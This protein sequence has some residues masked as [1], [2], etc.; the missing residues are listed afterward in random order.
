MFSDFDISSFFLSFK[1]LL[2]NCYSSTSVFY[3]RDSTQHMSA[4]KF[5]AM[6][7]DYVGQTD[8]TA[9]ENDR[10]LAAF[11][12]RHDPKRSKSL[13]VLRAD[14]DGSDKKPGPTTPHAW[15][16]KLNCDKRFLN[17]S[18]AF[19]FF[20]RWPAGIRLLIKCFIWDSERNE[21]C[22]EFTVLGSFFSFFSSRVYTWT[23]SRAV[24]GVLG[25]S[26]RALRSG[27]ESYL[28]GYF[29]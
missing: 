25:R 14:R 5:Y 15:G 9:V 29:I 4:F 23:L 6:S 27:S 8:T 17:C 20:Y 11:A 22:I 24:E 7:Y 10:P 3:D 18:S 28:I 2:R 19:F 12:C 21:E 13:T 26:E 16:V 1:Q